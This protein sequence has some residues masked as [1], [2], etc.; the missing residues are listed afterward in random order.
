M[1]L[2]PTNRCGLTQALILAFWPGLSHLMVGPTRKYRG[3]RVEELGAAMANNLV[4]VG[5]GT[6]TLHWDEFKALA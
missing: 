3:I 2:T 4:T 5:Q 1:I 6:E